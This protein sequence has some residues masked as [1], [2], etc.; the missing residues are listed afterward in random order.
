[1]GKLHLKRINAPNTWPIERKT[2]KWISRPRLGSQSM[3]KSLSLNTI[4]KEILKIVKTSKEVR[5]ILNKGLVKVDGKVRKDPN[6]PVS[7]LDVVSILDENYRLF[8]NTKRKLFLHKVKKTD[9]TI[10]PKKIIGKKIL[11][12]NKLQINFIDGNNLLSKEDKVKVSDTI[13]YEND[14]EK[15][16]LKFE[17]GSLIYLIEGKQVG[18]IG[19]IKEVQLSKG[20]QPTKILFQSEKKDYTTLKDFAIVVGKTKPV[21]EIPNE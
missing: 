21:I 9:A 6:F 20:T 18:K 4:I 2:T 13:V 3:N 10:K 5:A 11:K 19:V 1:M 12:G 14:K 7:I 17:K 16:K 8:I 15:D